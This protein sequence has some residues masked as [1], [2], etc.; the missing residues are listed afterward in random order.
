MAD[1]HVITMVPE[2]TQVHPRESCPSA[3][4]CILCK[5]TGHHDQSPLEKTALMKQATVGILILVILGAI[6]IGAAV[7]MLRMIR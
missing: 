2:G 6:V 3:N 5:L 7:M 4:K 1:N